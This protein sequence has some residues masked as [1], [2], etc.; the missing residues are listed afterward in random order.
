MRRRLV[1]TLVAFPLLLSMALV[2]CG[3]SDG[4]GGI[5]TANRTAEP[6]SDNEGG[7]GAEDLTEAERHEKELE[8]AQCMRDHGI[9]VPD[10]EPGE[11]IQIQVEGDP[12][13]HDAAMAECQP[14]LPGGGPGEGFDPEEQ[15]KM[16]AF[17]Q[18]MRDNGVESF[19][20]PKEGEGVHLGPEQAEDPDFEAADRTCNEEIFGGQ[21]ETNQRGGDGA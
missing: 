18:C 10:P 11:G 19:E 1:G 21:P 12:S 6:D 9:D 17:A 14:L 4:N 5:A 8:F 16:L 3:G 20:D 13:K 7:S 2:G 15:A